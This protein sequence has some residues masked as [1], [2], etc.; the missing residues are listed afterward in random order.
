MSRPSG[1]S[2]AGAL[3]L[4]S[5]LLQGGCASEPRT[6][7]GGTIEAPDRGESTTGR[8]HPERAQGG[9]GAAPASEA[10]GDDPA[11]L[12]VDAALRDLA[13]RLEAQAATGW[14]EHVP[15]SSKTKLPRLEIRSI[16][17]KTSMHVDTDA[18]EGRIAQA[19]LDG[20]RVT[21][22]ANRREREQAM[23]ERAYENAGDASELEAEEVVGLMLHGELADEVTEVDGERTR[24]VVLSLRILDARRA[25]TLLVA[26]GEAAMTTGR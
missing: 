5:L 22:A 19:L 4:A 13:T 3:A 23:D 7:S 26:R 6:V 20:G 10:P 1:L 25:K 17:N 9:R 12:A 14:P 8:R 11:A 2:T 21:L 15:L 24:T 16:V 18:L